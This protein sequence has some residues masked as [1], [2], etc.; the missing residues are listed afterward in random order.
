MHFHYKDDIPTV[1]QAVRQGIGFFVHPG[2][3]SVV[4]YCD[5]LV[6]TTA[7]EV[8]QEIRR[9]QTG[10]M[11]SLFDLEGVAIDWNEAVEQCMQLV[12]GTL[13]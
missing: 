13:P 5:N 3:P 7:A 12:E 2:H 8:L 6:N 9:I 11:T 1:E 4:D 10:E